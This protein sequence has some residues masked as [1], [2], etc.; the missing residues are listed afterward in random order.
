[1]IDLCAAD[2]A[3]RLA[4]YARSRRGAPLPGFWAERDLAPGD[5]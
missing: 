5:V 3:G 1:V 4:A 2:G